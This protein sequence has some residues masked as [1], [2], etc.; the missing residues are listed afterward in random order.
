[1]C[2]TRCNHAAAAAD[3]EPESALWKTAKGHRLVFL[4]PIVISPLC[5]L[6]LLFGLTVHLHQKWAPL[7]R[8]CTMCTA[9]RKCMLPVLVGRPFNESEA[10]C[11]LNQSKAKLTG[12]TYP[13]YV[14]PLILPSARGFT[15]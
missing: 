2:G 6:S 3:R 12:E 1:M 8:S 14:L 13:M 10:A 11:C 15:D 9:R 4:A 7:D 5:C